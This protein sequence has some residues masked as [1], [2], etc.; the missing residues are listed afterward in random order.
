MAF[1]ETGFKVA[2]ALHATLLK[3]PPY[4]N[5]S[6]LFKSGLPPG[7][8]TIEKIWHYVAWSFRQLEANVWPQLGPF[9]EDLSARGR[10]VL[11]SCVCVC[12]RENVYYWP[13]PRALWPAATDVQPVL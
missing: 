9:G 11:I 13:L 7:L 12:V 10:Q 5:Q 1:T 4:L 3:S 2:C 8:C 6:Q